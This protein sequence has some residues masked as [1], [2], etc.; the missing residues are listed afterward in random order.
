MSARGR[1]TAREAAAWDRL[2]RQLTAEAPGAL[3][4]APHVRARHGQGTAPMKRAA[5]ALVLGASLVA[6]VTSAV[7]GSGAAAVAAV[8]AWIGA[9][10]AAT[11]VFGPHPGAP[12]R[13]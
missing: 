3:Q 12:G 2:Q 8:M 1:L 10:S 6:L 4:R 7:G 9:V 11:A 5:A 13:R